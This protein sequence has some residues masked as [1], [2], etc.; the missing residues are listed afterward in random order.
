[1]LLDHSGMVQEEA[2]IRSVWQ[3]CDMLR[4]G[5]QRDE[6][7]RSEHE[8]IEDGW[9]EQFVVILSKWTGIRW[10][11]YE[12]DTKETRGWRERERG[13]GEQ[14]TWLL[15]QSARTLDELSLVTSNLARIYVR[16][17][18]HHTKTTIIFLIS[19]VYLHGKPVWRFIGRTASTFGYFH[20]LND[21]L[22]KVRQNQKRISYNLPKVCASDLIFIGIGEFI[23]QEQE[24]IKNE[25]KNSVFSIVTEKI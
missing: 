23:L 24:V 10:L 15:K 2:G 19:A 13:R 9:Q 17:C 25:K 6:C 11:R 4:W 16:S 22:E 21:L 5:R 8:R 20:G 3:T 1:M 7:T 14:S 12:Q 18:Y